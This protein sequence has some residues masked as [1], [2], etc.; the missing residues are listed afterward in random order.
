MI[1]EGIDAILLT[2]VNWEEITPS[3]QAL[4]EAG[5]KILNVDAQVK[6]MDY[7]DAYIGS[8]N[9]TAGQLCGEDLMEKQPEGGKIA[10]LE[11]PTRIL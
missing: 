4:Q 3:L 9:Y 8:D 1:D 7:V 10:I 6:E 11:C 5:I 2:P